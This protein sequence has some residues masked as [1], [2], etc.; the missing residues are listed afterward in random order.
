MAKT[1]NGKVPMPFL[2]ADK[3]VVVLK[4][5]NSSVAKGLGVSALITVQL[6]RGGH[7]D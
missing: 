4:L 2:G 3:L 6:A 7:R 1:R 5:D